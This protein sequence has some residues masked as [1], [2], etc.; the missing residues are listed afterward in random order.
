MRGVE[1][2]NSEIKL[3]K[4]IENSSDIITIISKEGIIKYGS[5]SARKIFNIKQGELIG[6]NVFELF[7][8]DD[9]SKMKRVFQEILETKEAVLIPEFKVRRPDRKIVYFDAIAR[10]LL[11]EPTIKGIVA[12]VR[13]ITS[14][15]LM[16]ESQRKLIELPRI[17]L[18]KYA[19]G[20]ALVKTSGEIEF[21]NTA[22]R[23]ITEFTQEELV[24]SSITKILPDNS[25]IK[26]LLIKTLNNLEEIKDLKTNVISKT[27]R[28]IP[29]RLSTNQINIDENKMI[30]TLEN[31]QKERKISKHL[32][33]FRKLLTRWAKISLFT[34]DYNAPIPLIS[35]NPSSTVKKNSEMLIKM[36]VHYFSIIGQ[37]QSWNTGLYGPLPVPDRKDLISLVFSFKKKNFMGENQLYLITLTFEK[38]LEKLLIIDRDKIEKT[39]NEITQSIKDPSQ[40]DLTFLIKTKIKVLND[41]IKN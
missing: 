11:E 15:K 23:E 6:K 3:E 7:H 37:G 12:N 24:G 17:I 41:Q 38:A 20:I 29:V 31:L 9:L 16:E 32:Y 8:E 13:D 21:S 30:I 1:V 4:L 34:F 28:K 35:E 14:K 39:L 36:S 22:L 2:E 27:G 18:E 5:P 19:N 25:L 10:N 26:E 33:E 40:I